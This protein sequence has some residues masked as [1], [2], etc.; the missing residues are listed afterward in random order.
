[1]DEPT[2][3]DDDTDRVVA[4]LRS[5]ADA[6]ER[7]VPPIST[8]DTTN[9]RRRPL[10][11]WLAAAAVVTLLGGA[12]ATY[13]VTRD[14]GDALQTV[15]ESPTETSIDLEIE[16]FPDLDDAC[17]EPRA[18]G[19]RVEDIQVMLPLVSDAEL[20]TQADD[21]GVT[22]SAVIEVGR[23]ELT[24]GALV[25]SDPD[26]QEPSAGDDTTTLE[27]CDP[28]SG[29]ET[30]S[31]VPAV[32][33]LDDDGA[34][35]L[36]AILSDGATSWTVTAGVQT[37]ARTDR[38]G[39]SADELE[40]ARR[41]LLR[42]LAGT[43][44]PA[45]SGVDS[46]GNGCD[47]PAVATIGGI[48]L[49][50]APASYSVGKPEV[51]EDQRGRRTT[52]VLRGPGDERIDV[53]YLATPDLA[54]AMTDEVPGGASEMTSARP[55][56]IIAGS[57]PDEAVR[58]GDAGVEIRSDEDRIVYGS[59][60]GQDPAGGPAGWMVIGSGGVVI[61]TVLEVVESLRY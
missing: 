53:V 22:Y 46:I 19:P 8:I 14:G 60:H 31:T 10:R 59:Q 33:L 9:A 42:L 47:G 13:A 1:M 37:G 5:Y 39:A 11:P 25:F 21:D 45:P 55:C 24:V 26:V 28:F 2:T 54:G 56:R 36:V 48:E 3:H 16:H 40:G 27:I 58:S 35:R 15:D 29:A 6:A 38:L 17:P 49:V 41:L 23:G 20:F 57:A 50:A 12:L 61:D 18:D 34:L 52:V 51:I 43:S 32:W 44:W 4:Q 30:R 7:T